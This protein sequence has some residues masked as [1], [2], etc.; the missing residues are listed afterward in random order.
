MSKE[1]IIPTTREYSL[2]IIMPAIRPDKW[3]GVV[4]SIEKAYSGK[5]ELIIVSPYPLPVSMNDDTRIK[6]VKDHGNPVRASNIG[7][8]LCEYELVTWT[9]DD[10]VYLPNSLDEMV[11]DYHFMEEDEYEKVIVGK[12]YEGQDGTDK[13]LQP[14]S[15]FKV[16]GSLSTKLPNIPDDYWLFNIALMTRTFFDRLGYWDNRYEACPMA[17]SD[18]AVRAQ[19]HGAKVKMCGTPILDCGHMP[20]TSGDHAPIHYAQLTHDE[21]LFKN[22]WK[23]TKLIAH[24]TNTEDWKR[25]SRVWDRRFS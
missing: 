6:Y 19:R 2:S 11:K 20:G 13:P 1:L 23:S 3:Q 9:A 7:A 8:M 12:Y 10:A 25:V 16:N 24:V 18:M 15:Y 17:H 14:D 4:R 21:P 22:I 5:W